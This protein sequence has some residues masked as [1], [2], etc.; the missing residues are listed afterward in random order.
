[1]NEISLSLTINKKEY[2]NTVKRFEYICCLW[3]FLSHQIVKAP[4]EIK[5][6]ANLHT[7]NPIY[8]HHLITSRP[9]ELCA[10]GIGFP[11]VARAQCAR[12]HIEKK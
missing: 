5:S 12:A 6:L 3:G 10:D 4:L 2:E 8:E 9:R 7:R 11:N 1:M